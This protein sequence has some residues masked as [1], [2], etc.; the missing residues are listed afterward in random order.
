M[1]VPR[2]WRHYFVSMRLGAGKG[3]ECGLA[4]APH[5]VRGACARPPSL[6]RRE[7]GRAR[8]RLRTEGTVPAARG[9][10]ARFASMATILERERTG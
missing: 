8:P 3:L 10:G 1:V 7:D 5:G 2:C 9:R 4:T 6:K